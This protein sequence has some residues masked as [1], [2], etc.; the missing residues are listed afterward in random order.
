MAIS[1]H[2]SGSFD[3]TLKFL[4]IMTSGRIF[5]ELGRQAQKGVDALAKDT[6][7]DTGMTAASWNYEVQ[8]D[9]E[10][11]SISW[12]NNNVNQGVNIA[13]IL[14]FGHGT[15]TGGYVSGRNYITPAIAPVFEEI[16]EDVW[17]AVTSA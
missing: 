6:P 11:W 16:A 3:K 15:G 4:G 10:G 7:I 1:F 13:I 17:K 8:N 5:R 2:H 14:H 12:N 9:N